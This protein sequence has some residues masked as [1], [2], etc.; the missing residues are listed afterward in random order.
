MQRLLANTGDRSGKTEMLPYHE[1]R[2]FGDQGG[3]ASEFAL[4]QL[5]YGFSH[6]PTAGKIDYVGHAVRL[7]S[8]RALN[9]CHFSSFKGLA[10]QAHASKAYVK[11][12]ISEVLRYGRNMTQGP[13]L[14][15]QE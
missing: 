3:C 11:R 14:P 15:V 12:N 13:G 9:W 4:L 7:G 2:G 8:W 5:M 6:G 1:S 10:S